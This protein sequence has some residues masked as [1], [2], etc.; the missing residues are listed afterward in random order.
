[1]AAFFAAVGVSIFLLDIK[2]LSSPNIWAT[3]K[4]PALLKKASFELHIWY[5]I[6]DVGY[7]K[8]IK[9]WGGCLFCCRLCLDTFLDTK[10]LSSPSMWTTA[11]Q[12]ALLKKFPFE[13]LCLI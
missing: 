1:M 12:V 9:I 8:M 10:K 3:E 4:Q 5:T 6:R 2:K 11:K 13:V 7:Q